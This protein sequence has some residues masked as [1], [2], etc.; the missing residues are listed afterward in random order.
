MGIRDAL[1]ALVGGSSRTVEYYGPNFREMVLGLTEEELYRTQPHLRTVL[2]FVARNV[3]HLG[4]KAFKRNAD[5]GRE[6]LRNDPLSLL[7]QRPNADMTGFELLESLASDMGLYD[8]AFWHLAESNQMPSGFELTPIPPSWVTMRGGNA[9]APKRYLVLAPGAYEP[10]SVPA[11]DMIVF[12]GWNPGDPKK[13]TSPVATLKQVL[14][15]QVQAWSYRQQMWKRAGRVGMV[16]TRPKDAPWSDTARNRF[17]TDL[18]SEWVDSDGAKAGS[19]LLLEDGMTAERMGFNAREDQWAEVAKVALSTVAS[20]FHV[21]PVMVGILDNANFSNTKEFR[22]MLYSET[23]GPTLARIEDRINA[24][25]VP[26]VSND[27]DAYVE[28]NIEEKLQGDFEE[29]AA[30]LSTATGAPWMTRNEVRALRNLP[31]IDGGDELVVPLNVL[32]GG[33]ASPRDSGTQNEKSRD[34]GELMQVK[35]FGLRGKAFGSASDE[36]VIGTVLAKFF[37]HQREAVLARV[38]GAKAASWWD[39][40]GWDKKLTEDLFR[41]SYA[42]TQDVAARVLDRLGLDESDYDVSRTIPFLM[43]VA[44]SRAGAINSTTYEQ[45]K[46]ILDGEGPED[47]DAA[48]VFDLIEESR[49]PQMVG[50][51]AT[52]YAAFAT[53]EAAKQNGAAQKSWIVTSGNPRPEHAAMDGETVGLDDNFS[54]GAKYPGDSILGA[55]GVSGCTCDVEVRF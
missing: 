25:L 20:V 50:T 13:G 8:I 24:F 23:L 36:A 37:K 42:V 6:R 2:S 12:H 28:F 1:A 44:K 34:L 9:F 39:S 17:L 21:N 3:A 46:T 27:L 22:K 49:M 45:L 26:R 15:E 10:I 47:V 4:L 16:L 48:H 43:A 11:E 51:L 52:T 40:A 32:M 35:S 30:I 19:G 5:G 14:A 55:D 33:Q 18:K 54:N 29:Q 7:L 38:N 41:A 31:A 53:V